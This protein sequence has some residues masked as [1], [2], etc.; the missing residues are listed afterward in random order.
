[1]SSLADLPELVGFFSYSREDD[2]DSHGALSA[3]RNRIQ[4]ELRGQLGR[5][6]KTFRLWQ[7]KEAIPSGTLWESEIKNAAAQS[8]FFI[9]IITPTVV[10]SPYCRFE[11][12]SFLA[13]E[14]ALGR[15][16]LVFPILYIDVPGLEDAAERKRPGPFAHCQAPICGLAQVAPP[17]CRFDRCQRGGRAILHAYPQRAAPGLGFAGRAQAARGSRCAAAS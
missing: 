11:L 6:A 16:D 13:R 12:E 7:D 3:L 10:A 9:P 17:R 14:A 1:M 2:A 8:V 15:D 4:G 5:T